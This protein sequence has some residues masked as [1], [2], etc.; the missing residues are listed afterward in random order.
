MCGGGGGG[1]RQENWVVVCGPLLKTL[2]LFKGEVSRTANTQFIT[3]QPNVYRSGPTFSSYV[4]SV[5]QNV[6]P[7]LNANE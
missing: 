7:N 4:R 2:T 1:Y 3:R 6:V 5:K